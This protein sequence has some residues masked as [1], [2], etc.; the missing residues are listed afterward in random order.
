RRVII[1]NSANSATDFGPQF[2]FIVGGNILGRGL[3]IDNLLT[4][5]YVR[6]ARTTQMDTM[7][8]HARMY[9]YREPLMP[10]TRV[11]LPQRLA[12]RFHRIHEAETALRRLLADPVERTRV[13]VQVAGALRPTRPGILDVGSIGAYRPGQ[14]VYPVQPAY[15]PDDLGTTTMR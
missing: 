6:R 8:Q 14:Q 7:L 15:K 11:F 13:P 2:N 9:G 4:T 12:V 1:V 10:F 5:Y 3:T